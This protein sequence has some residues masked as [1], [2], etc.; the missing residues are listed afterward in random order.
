VEIPVSTD[1]AA[2]QRILTINAHEAW[3][4]QLGYLGDAI[5]IVDGM[6][7]RYCS[8]W[9]RRIRPIPEHATIVTLES[10]LAAQRAPDARPYDCVVAHSVTDLMDLK[11]VRGPRVLVLHV[12]LEGRVRNEGAAAVPPGYAKSVKQ[13]LDMIGGQAMA[14]A[15]LKAKSWDIEAPVVTCGVD[16]EGYR[17]H[18]GTIAAGIRVANQIGTRKDYF[19]WAFHERAFRDIPLRIVGHNPDM[20]GV[21][22]ADDWDHLKLLLSQH[23][24]FVHTAHPDLEDGFNMATVEAMAAGL[25]VLG[26]RHPS[27]PIEHGVSGFLS[28]DPEQLA[29]HAKTLLRDPALAREMGRAARD[30]ARAHFSVARFTKGFRDIVHL[31]EQKWN[32]GARA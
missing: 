10:M 6:P 18:D 13:Y 14:V 12:T 15:P 3:V 32:R 8:S 23:R 9:D 16:V 26:N 17:P 20:P 5:D 1:S 29:E 11:Q 28:D 31:A 30:T 24:F 27:S 22:P 4:H 21:A 7:G 19:Y 2:R 25:P